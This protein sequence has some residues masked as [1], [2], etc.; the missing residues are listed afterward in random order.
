MQFLPPGGSNKKNWRSKADA[1][2]ETR[3][4]KFVMKKGASSVSVGAVGADRLV[5]APPPLNSVKDGFWHL[6]L[7][8][9]VL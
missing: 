3:R 1:T 9:H 5:G 4:Q 8:A 7:S 2:T 6:V